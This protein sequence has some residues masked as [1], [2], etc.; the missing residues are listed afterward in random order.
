MN[1]EE[2]FQQLKSQ[3][4]NELEKN[5]SCLE[6]F[7]AALATGMLK[8]GTD[9]VDAVTGAGGR[10]VDGLTKMFGG[11]SSLV[12][13]YGPE[14]ASTAAVLGGTTLG[15]LA[16]GANK[17]LDNEDKALNERKALVNRYRQLTENV[18]SD[19]GIH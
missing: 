10:A 18:K 12:A 14:I 4:I 15:G 8:E 7:E 2:E 17:S 6:A 19:Y 1:R 13:R 16:Y 11:L 5:G 3:L 9:A